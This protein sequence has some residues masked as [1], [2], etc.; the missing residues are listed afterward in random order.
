LSQ[1]H[2]FALSEFYPYDDYVNSY[3]D[4]NIIDDIHLNSGDD[5]VNITHYYEIKSSNMKIFLDKIK[6][7][8]VSLG[9][10]KRNFLNRKQHHNIKINT[11]TKF[12][13]SNYFF[14]NHSLEV[15]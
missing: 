11:F 4:I 14:N 8:F 3:D 1:R 9:Q 6:K 13:N 15:C 12:L 5:L 10:M 7:I 2:S